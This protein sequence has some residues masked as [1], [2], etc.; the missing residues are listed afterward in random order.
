MA[1][2]VGKRYASSLFEVGI[3]LKKVDDFHR[4][5]G[6]IKETFQSEERLLQILEHPRISRKEKHEL[7]KDIFGKN[8][9]DKILNF[10]FIIIDKRREDSIMD[11]V[12]EYNTLFKEY[13]NILEIEAITAVPMEEKAKDRLKLALKSKFHKEIHLSNSVDDSIIGGVLLKMDQK[14]IDSTLRGHL[15]EMETVIKGVSL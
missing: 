11:I 6:F 3:E 2:L 1:E 12:E 7:I 9:S 8:I 4:Q 14:I 5:I 15:K 10:L 13:K